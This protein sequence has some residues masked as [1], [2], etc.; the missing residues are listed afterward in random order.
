MEKISADYQK[1]IINN[2][3]KDKKINYK[4]FPSVLAYFDGFV[5]TFNSCYN[6]SLL[7]QSGQ[8]KLDTPEKIKDFILSIASMNP[9]IEKPL[10]E[11]V[12]KMEQFLTCE[13]LK[14]GSEQVISLAADITALNKLAAD[15]AHDVLTD[16]TVC[17]EVIKNSKRDF[18]QVFDERL[19]KLETFCKDLG[20]DYSQ[21]INGIKTS[22]S[23]AF[24]LGN[25][26]A[27]ILIDKWLQN[28]ISKDSIKKSFTQ[29]VIQGYKFNPDAGQS[30]TSSVRG[31]IR[32]GDIPNPSHYIPEK[33]LRRRRGQ[34]CAQ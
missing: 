26:D 3:E 17:K 28:E 9:V 18:D 21:Q 24:K 1:K 16:K 15:V 11:D 10:S 12:N 27:S 6:S 23:T 20:E 31:S 29:I 34:C 2:L 5:A 30:D 14:I 33:P 4:D 22:S 25:N 7:V 32:G 19:A 8:V 13:N